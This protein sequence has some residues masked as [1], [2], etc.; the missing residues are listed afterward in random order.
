MIVAEPRNRVH[1]RHSGPSAAV[2]INSSRN[3]GGFLG[4]REVTIQKNCA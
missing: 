2:R 4:L 1:S 3:P